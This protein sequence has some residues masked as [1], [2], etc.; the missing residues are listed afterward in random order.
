M[1]VGGCYETNC[2]L[3]IG[4]FPLTLFVVCFEL[5]RATTVIGGSGFRDA[6]NALIPVREEYLDDT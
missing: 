5:V 1:T 3:L 4:L 6:C 2:S